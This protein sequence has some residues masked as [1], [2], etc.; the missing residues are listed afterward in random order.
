MDKP[1]PQNYLRKSTA[2]S[3]YKE[4]KKSYRKYA[5]NV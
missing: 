5:L 1:K 4:S 2:G 3:R